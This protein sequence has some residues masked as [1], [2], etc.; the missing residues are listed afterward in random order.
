MHVRVHVCVHVCVHACVQVCVHAC[1][2]C[3]CVLARA[4]WGSTF[5]SQRRI[6][7]TKCQRKYRGRGQHRK[8]GIELTESRAYASA[9]VQPYAFYSALV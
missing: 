2:V 4:R 8:H 9:V 5:A 1:V 3:D 6:V 7:G